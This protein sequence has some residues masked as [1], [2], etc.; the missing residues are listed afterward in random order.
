MIVFQEGEDAFLLSCPF[1]EGLDDY[2][3]NYVLYKLLGRRVSEIDA[4]ND[5]NVLETSGE[6]IGL[7][8]VVRLEFDDSGRKELKLR[9]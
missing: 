9:D 6:R 3:D 4:I 8:P 1:D 2:S 7:I 5:W